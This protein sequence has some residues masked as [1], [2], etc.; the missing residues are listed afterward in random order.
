MRPLFWCQE[1]R[2]VFNGRPL[3]DFNVN[4]IKRALM[5][6][7]LEPTCRP[8]SVAFDVWSEAHDQIR[9]AWELA[10]DSRAQMR[11]GVG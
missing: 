4:E 1:G 5:S 9:R 3:S 11:K 6:E 10:L 8:G 7:A 2:V